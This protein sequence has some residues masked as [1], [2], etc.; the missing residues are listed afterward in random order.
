MFNHLLC[1]QNEHVEAMSEHIGDQSNLQ[2]RYETEKWEKFWERSTRVH[3]VSCFFCCFFF[4]SFF[5]DLVTHPSSG[6]VYTKWAFF[7]WQ[8]AWMH[9]ESRCNVSITQILLVWA[10]NLKKKSKNDNT[11]PST[12]QSGD[13]IYTHTNPWKKGYC[14]YFSFSLSL[15]R[16]KNILKL[17]YSVWFVFFCFFDRKQKTKRYDRLFSSFAGIYKRMCPCLLLP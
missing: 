3:H 4:L 15:K 9:I 2:Q 8:V 13:C 12:K 11:A 17:I 16:A 6:G 7:G 10:N 1:H 5:C 14:S